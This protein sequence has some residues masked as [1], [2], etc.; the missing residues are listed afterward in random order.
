MVLILCITENLLSSSSYRVPLIFLYT[1]PSHADT[2]LTHSNLSTVLNHVE[3]M[4]KLIDC[5][6]LPYSVTVIVRDE[7]KD[8]EQQR[9]EYVYYWRNVSPYSMIGWGY[10]GGW[11]HY[12]GQEAALRAAKEYIQ[13]DPGIYTGVTKAC[14]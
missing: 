6:Y 10:L 9:D 13:R 3:D 11:L 4:D 14:V 2:T 1:F 5:L 7:S 12:W 8:E